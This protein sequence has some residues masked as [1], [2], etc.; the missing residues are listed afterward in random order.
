[1]LNIKKIFHVL[2][3]SILIGV[4]VSGCSKNP[5]TDTPFLHI[6]GEPAPI[7]A[8]GGNTEIEFDTN[9]PW[10]IIPQPDANGQTGW[11]QI[12]PLFGEAGK[13]TVTIGINPNK[14]YEDRQ[15][16]L[17][18][19]TASLSEPVLIRQ[20]KTNAILLDNTLRRV[21]AAEGTLAVQLRAN[22]EYS[23]TIEQEEEWLSE[24]RPLSTSSLKDSAHTFRFMPNTVEKERTATVIFKS[25]DSQL[26]D[27]LTVVQEAWTDPDPQRTALVSIYESAG[28]AG[29]I[30]NDNWCSEKPLD[31]WYGVETD[32]EGCVT[33]LHLGRNNLTGKIPGN[34]SNLTKLENLDLSWN[35]IEQDIN[36][37]DT[38][39]NTATLVSIDMSHNKL[40]GKVM[41]R[42]WYR[43]R[44][45]ERV[46]LASNRIQ[47]YA[48][49]SQWTKF[50]FTNDRMVEFILNDNQMTGSVPMAIQ[51]HPEWNR[52]A[53]QIIRQGSKSLDYLNEPILPDFSFTD[54]RDGSQHSI[55]DI[56]GSNKMTMLVHWDPTQEASTQFV[57][58]AVERL[59]TLYGN[60]GFAA[61]GIVPEGER[62]REAAQ[63]YLH[64]NQISW[65]VVAD[66]ADGQGRRIILPDYPYP[67]YLMIDK[68]G[69]VMLD[70]FEGKQLNSGNMDLAS[71]EHTDDLNFFLLQNLGFA[72][73][74]SKDYSMDKQ[75]KQLQQATQGNGINVV[76]LGDAFTDAD[77]RSGFYEEVMNW[78]MEAFFALE[79]MRTYREYFNV[80]MVYAVSSSTTIDESNRSALGSTIGPN[81]SI[82]PDLNKVRE[83]VSTCNVD[84][85]TAVP[86]VVVNNYDANITFMNTTP[87]HVPFTGFFPGDRKAFINTFIHESVGHAFGQLGD[88]IV[89]YDPGKPGIIP[90]S[91]KEVLTKY[92]ERGW[93]R[94][95]SLTDDQEKVFWSHLIEHPNYLYVYIY[96]G[97][98]TYSSGVW[99]S[100]QFSIMRHVWSSLYFNAISR[101]LI[102]QRILKLAGEAYSFDRFVQKDSDE[103]RGGPKNQTSN[104]AS[105]RMQR[106]HYPPVVVE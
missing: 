72:T 87:P 44:Q 48:F 29:W 28:G 60:D 104:T 92:H 4:L 31:Q 47:A 58:T 64:G 2:S 75:Y 32:S 71:F 94:N 95:L 84:V 68:A 10:R 20:L 13:N 88:E 16:I 23:V 7:S 1:M 52:L 76:L 8:E 61:V 63:A 51:N 14:T 22:V 97:G 73:Y 62:Y 78:S 77:I 35:A 105:D 79:P 81:G 55:R 18:F 69:K 50:F 17:L 40:Y 59:H 37:F 101:E 42:N 45:L 90:E 53:F 93:Y 106:K 27:K 11:L 21:S 102:V 33:A 99:R 3:T 100:E 98:Y 80:Y 54:L 89:T 43:L 34:I 15:I 74:R 46:N 24:K 25:K 85:S 96:A 30:K 67:S 66:Y 83:Y 5:D 26:S 91:E 19:K 82:D 39:S 41:P 103:G 49:P 57:S 86:A 65:M 56:Y 6:D 38:L 70:A 9:E 12:Y 36:E